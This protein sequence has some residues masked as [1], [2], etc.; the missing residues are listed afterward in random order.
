MAAAN[1]EDAVHAEQARED[2][3]RI[4]KH[5]AA[6]LA[7]EEVNIAKLALPEQSETI[8]RA[9]QRLQKSMIVQR[10]VTNDQNLEEL[11]EAILHFIDMT[12]GKEAV[13]TYI[14]AILEE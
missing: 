9:A 6:K 4:G 14:G 12:G 8:L 7:T 10:L 3:L 2:T 13:D 1:Y 5:I 11:A